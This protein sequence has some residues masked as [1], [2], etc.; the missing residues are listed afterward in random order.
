[1]NTLIVVANIL[2]GWSLGSGNIYNEILILALVIVMVTLL[3]SAIVV[4]KALK[5]V[6][7]VTMPE[8]AKEQALAKKKKKFS[9]KKFWDKFLELRPIEQEKDLEI[10]DHEYDGIKELDNPIPVWFNALFYSTVVF[11]VV[12]LLVYHVFGWGLNQDQEYAR[13]MELAEIAKQEYLSQ[14][15][16]LIDESSVTIDASGVAAG[17]S[18]FAANCAV[19][20]GG[21][22]EGGIGPNL[23]DDFWLHGGNIKDVFSVVKY[24]VPDKG[25]VAWEQT[26][27]PGQIAEVSN[28][29][30]TLRGTNPPSAKEAQGSKFEYSDGEQSETDAE[31]ATADAEEV[32]EGEESTTL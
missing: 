21:S 15:A 1:M 16:N 9:W 19:C 3:F 14:A 26:L 32:V 23:A 4:H 5:A 29:I 31:A 24:G 20:H 30:V 8:A 17:Q 6:I 28:Y 7:N 12:Y 22:G 13:E 18:I 27:T 2:E 11:G 25:M 10:E